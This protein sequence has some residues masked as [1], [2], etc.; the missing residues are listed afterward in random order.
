MCSR[1]LGFLAGGGSMLP[2]PAAAAAGAPFG[3]PAPLTVGASGDA[4][5]LLPA[6]A[7]APLL[8]APLLLG[9]G[10]AAPTSPASSAPAAPDAA[11]ALAAFFLAFFSRSAASLA[12]SFLR[13][14]S[15]WSSGGLTGIQSSAAAACPPI[16]STTTAGTSLT[17][18]SATVSP[19]LRCAR[20]LKRPLN[21]RPVIGQQNA[22]SLPGWC[23]P[24][25]AALGAAFCLL[26]LGS[27]LSSTTLFNPVM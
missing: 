22:A 19:V 1:A 18:F 8:P 7:A 14:S 21:S 20:N 15:S 2:G 9:P 13:M 23:M 17:A 4:D 6:A 10:P 25:S 5:R 24:R 16:S 12:A 3:P 26:G 27:S 11:A